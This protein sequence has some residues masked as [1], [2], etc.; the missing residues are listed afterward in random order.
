MPRLNCSQ[1]LALLTPSPSLPASPDRLRAA[2]AAM[3][4]SA[5]D[6]AT[7]LFVIA[8]RESSFDLAATNPTSSAV[9]LFQ[10]LR[11]TADDIQD[12]V[13]ANFMAPGTTIPDLASNQRLADHRTNPKAAAFGAYVY[14][15]DRI[16]SA[17]NNVDTGIARYGTGTEYATWVR[18]AVRAVRRV[19]QLPVDQ[20]TEL[21][22][23]TRVAHER[24][25]EL[26]AAMQAV[27]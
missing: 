22:T 21:V 12:R 2:L 14:L 13:L 11:P 20:M 1:V 6:A 4:A 15:L 16:A 10:V 18:S 23:F 8:F 25:Q 27:T 17:S 3:T 9:G 5:T 7:T 24:C 19:C 26:R